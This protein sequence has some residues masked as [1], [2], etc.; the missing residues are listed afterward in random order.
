MAGLISKGITLGYSTSGT[1]T[2]TTLNNLRDI[3]DLGGST[4]TIETTVLSDSAHTYIKG[5]ED[6]GTSLDFTFLYEKTQF[7]TLDALTGDVNWKVTLSDGSTFAFTGSCSVRLSGVGTND[8]VE[9]VLSVVP[10]SAMTFTA[11]T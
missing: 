1:S 8:V 2:Y 10:S 4:D 5:L 3:P 7:G 6:Y 9:M 11:G